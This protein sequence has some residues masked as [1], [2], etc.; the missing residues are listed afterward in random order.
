MQE[1][2]CKIRKLEWAKFVIHI[3]IVG[4][5]TKIQY[6]KT[7]IEQKKLS[8]KKDLLTREQMSVEDAY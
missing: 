8:H 5:K 2:L 7:R 1:N 3:R 4:K 6:S